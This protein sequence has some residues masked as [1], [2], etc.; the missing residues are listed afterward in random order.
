[1]HRVNET[2]LDHYNHNYQLEVLLYFLRSEVIG[3]VIARNK[4]EMGRSYYFP[5]LL[6]TM[7]MNE[8]LLLLR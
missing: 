4:S 3:T 6:S 8:L 5:S 2:R 7:N 1:M